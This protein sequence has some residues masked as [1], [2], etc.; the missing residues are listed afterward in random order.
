MNQVF[1]N[2]L[3]NAID[4]LKERRVRVY[5]TEVRSQQ[6]EDYLPP[7]ITIRT[8]IQEMSRQAP[9]PHCSLLSSHLVIQIADNGSGMSESVRSRIFDPFFTTKPIGSGTGLGLAISYQIVVEHHKGTLQVA[10]TEG[11]GT[12]FVIQLPLRQNLA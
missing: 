6:E 11:R 9:T 7:S 10:S 2:I 1:M 4:A 12:E 8:G 5:D 3:S